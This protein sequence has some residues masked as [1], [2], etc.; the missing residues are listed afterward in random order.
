M[1]VSLRGLGLL[2]WERNHQLFYVLCDGRVSDPLAKASSR[3]CLPSELR[4]LWDR[5]LG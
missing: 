5:T 3:W 1:A 2:C 4:R